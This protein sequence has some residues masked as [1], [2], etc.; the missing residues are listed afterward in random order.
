MS[1]RLYTDLSCSTHLDDAVLLLNMLSLVSHFVSKFK[2]C[3]TV[4]PALQLDF[5]SLN[6]FLKSQQSDDS[7]FSSFYFNNLSAE[8]TITELV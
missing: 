4:Q 8:R 2:V 6:F 7:W 5:T 3:G 1:V